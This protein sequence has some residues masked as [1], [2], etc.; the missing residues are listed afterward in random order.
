MERPIKVQGHRNERCHLKKFCDHGYNN[1]SEIE[2]KEDIRVNRGTF[3]LILSKNQHFPKHKRAM[4]ALY[5][6]F[7]E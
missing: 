4:P 3:E 7:Y 6:K 1:W 5:F 2:L